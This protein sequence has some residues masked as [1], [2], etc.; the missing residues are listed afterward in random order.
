MEK[1]YNYIFK[2]YNMPFSEL[3]KIN[4]LF[5]NKTDLDKIKNET[6]S[7]NSVFI[8]IKKKI[9]EIKGLDSIESG[10]IGMGF[11]FRRWI[12]YGE[13]SPDDIS[14]EV[15]DK[16]LLTNNLKY[17]KLIVTVRNIQDELIKLD[18]IILINLIKEQFVG[19]PI[20]KNQLF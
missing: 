20:N 13:G 10:Y 17:L 9:M 11:L 4:A 6:S 19:T 1:K 15:L 16:I 5:I 8:E 14:F 2:C 7:Q 12:K 18:D 3:V